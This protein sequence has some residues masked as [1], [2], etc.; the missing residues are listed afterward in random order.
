MPSQKS[1]AHTRILNRNC[2]YVIFYWFACNTQCSL[3]WMFNLRAHVPPFV[4]GSWQQGLAWRKGFIGVL[5][6]LT[7]KSLGTVIKMASRFGDE[8]AYLALLVHWR[9]SP[10]YLEHP[11]FMS[12]YK[13]LLT[14]LSVVNVSLC[15]GVVVSP[16]QKDEQFGQIHRTLRLFFSLVLVKFEHLFWQWYSIKEVTN[17]GLTHF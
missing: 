14:F 10:A 11:L 16:P 5:G 17:E 15:F 2:V 13:F 9:C 12:R 4:V 8:K 1:S 3:Q 6:G 7:P